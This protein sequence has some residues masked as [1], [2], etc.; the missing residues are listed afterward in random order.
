MPLLHGYMSHLIPKQWFFLSDYLCQT[1]GL[2]L[3][4]QCALI[5]SVQLCT[6]CPIN[7]S[8]YL[9][10]FSKSCME[11]FRV[12]NKKRRATLW[13]FFFLFLFLA[14][15]IWQALFFSVGS[16]SYQ[17]NFQSSTNILLAASGIFTSITSS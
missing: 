9:F 5:T 15:W 13:P 14:L 6:T 11:C 16:Y 12:W 17:L 2:E 8:R 1:A 7:N 10:K 3:P 4:D